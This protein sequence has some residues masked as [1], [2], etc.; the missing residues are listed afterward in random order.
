MPVTVR[1]WLMRDKG[2]F[3]LGTARG[4]WR[5]ENVSSGLLSRLGLRP[6]S[7]VVV[8]GERRD[9][10]VLD[11]EDI[12]VRRRSGR[13]RP[14][15]VADPVPQ[16]FV[17]SDLRLTAHRWLR[18]AGC[19]EVSLP[20]RHYG[21]RHPVASDRDADGGG[22]DA[23]EGDLTECVREAV[24][25]GLDRFFAFVRRPTLASD[26]D[27]QLAEREHLLVVDDED[28]VD[29]AMGFVGQLVGEL[30]ATAGLPLDPGSVLV[31]PL[32]AARLQRLEIPESW[33]APVRQV[34]RA[35]LLA[36][37][38]TLHEAVRADGR[39]AW[40]VDPGERPAQ[41]ARI[42][43]ITD[44]VLLETASH[45]PGPAPTW[46]RDPSHPATATLA[47][48]PA[49]LA[50]VWSLDGAGYVAAVAWDELVM[51]VCQ[52]PSPSS[53]QLF[54]RRRSLREVSRAR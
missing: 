53:A 34:L 46:Y 1:G 31:V 29:A 18:A 32:R 20:A 14:A 43:D 15:F 24:H 5:L 41:V 16:L 37:G 38:A 10:A 36:Q 3:Y 47:V 17:G 50:S 2:L 13:A 27:E 9:G 48:G 54:P 23:G 6:E 39:T 51:V 35:R 42:L 30:S 4:W 19:V 33:S 21:P 8:R 45:R 12:R 28:D 11:I 44:A 26:V 25:A 22:F 49:T 7:P 40:L 52:L